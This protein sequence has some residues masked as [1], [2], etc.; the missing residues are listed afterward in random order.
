[1][2]MTSM[3]EIT[4]LDN[5][6]KIWEN[7]FDSFYATVYVPVNGLPD[8]IINY[9]FKMPYLLVLP[10]QKLNK[11]EA[12][13]YADKNGFTQIAAAYGGSVVFIYPACEGGWDNADTDMYRELI[14]NSKLNQYYRDGAAT[15]IDRFTGKPAGLF[16]RGAIFRVYLYGYGASADYI[17]RSCLT[18]VNGE[19]LWGPGEITPAVCSLERMRAKLPE[20][21]LRRDIPIISIGNGTELN[22]AIKESFEHVLIKDTAEVEKDFYAFTRKYRRWCGNL[23]I[24]P[25]LDEL[26]MVCE[27]VIEELTMSGDN[28][29]DDSPA[30][31]DGYENMKNIEETA[32]NE[33]THRVGALAFYNRGLFDKGPAPLLLAFHGGGDSAMYISY[34]S[35]W[36]EVAHKHN[37][38]LVALEN[39]LNSTATEMIELIDRLAE[40]Y[41]IDRSRIYGSGFSMGGC[42]SWDLCQEYPEV[43]AGLAPMDAT[44]E[45]GLNSYGRPAPKPINR[46]TAVPIFYSGGEITPL[47]ELPFQAEKCWDRMRYVFEINRLTTPY[48]VRFE[49]REN[50]ADKIWGIS[51]DRV[52]RIY[53]TSRDSWLT[54]NYFDSEDG[55]CRTV[56]T[57]VSGQGHEC[58][59]H[60]CEQAWQFLSQF[61]R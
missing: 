47:P 13:E 16:I 31:R 28:L 59:H 2:G 45:V 56:F 15:P 14:A 18:T 10:E 24:E 55:V 52:E 42:K 40:K 36:Y 46:T 29:G 60:T 26:G 61:T 17:A 35:G 9:G 11:Q 12:A 44:F 27:P 19:Y 50:W 1:M 4:V 6:N 23:E 33:L 53:D 25:D 32:G 49:D 7:R 51:G 54:L 30:H 21:G 41:N 37:F 57:S 34:I 43:F 39:H 48:N 20:E 5:G 3:P 58:R 8:D 38:L 22:A